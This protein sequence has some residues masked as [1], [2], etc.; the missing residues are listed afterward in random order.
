MY[1]IACCYASGATSEL[2][3]GFL[4]SVY[5]F[6][7]RERSNSRNEMSDKI[8]HLLT[9]MSNYLGACIRVVPIL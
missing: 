8:M 9:N 4:L 2:D 6:S 7:K 1:V 5:R 3:H